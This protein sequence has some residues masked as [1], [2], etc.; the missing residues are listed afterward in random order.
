MNSTKQIT[1]GIC[2]LLFICISK[3]QNTVKGA[4][5]VNQVKQ[6]IDSLLQDYNGHEPGVS[7][8]IL[9]DNELILE[10]QLGLANMEHQIP[11]TTKT[12]FHVA[13]VSKQFTAFAI[14]LLEYEGKLSLDDTIRKY[15]PEM[16]EFEHPITIRNLMNHT[17]GLKDQ[18]N[19]LRLS[20]WT[21]SDLITN[22]QTL[23]ILF[24]QKTLNFQPNEK[25]MY[26]NSGYTLLA[27]IVSRVSNMSFSNFMN[28]NVFRPLQMNDTE[29]VDTEGQI[30]KYKSNSYYKSNSTYKEDLFNNYSVGATNLN[31]TVKD[32]SKWAINFTTKRVGNA[33]IFKKMYLETPLNNGNFYCYASGF[34]INSYKGFERIEHS[35]QDA[36]YQ[37]YLATFPELNLSI[38]FTNT[39]GEINGARMVYDIIDICLEPYV[40]SKKST[41]SSKTLLTHKKPI[42]TTTSYLKQFEGYYWNDKD[43]YSRQ[44]KVQ[45]D[46]LQYIRNNND[47]TG[48]IPV[49]KNE[50]EMVIDEYVSILFQSNQIVLT[51]DDG[52]QITLDKY[53]PVAYDS[54]S[55]KQFVGR[56]Y[57]PELNTY[58]SFSVK[59]NNL[60]ANHTRLGD[61]KLSAIK[62]DYF[63]GNKGSFL[64]VVF[65]RD[66]ADRVMGFNVS[67]SRAKEV[68]FQ[69]LQ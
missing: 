22:D 18:Y 23:Q 11:I 33:S 37:A 63:I 15:L 35:G 29:F 42:R 64:K 28:N 17:S 12:S 8:G 51:L 19:L 9:K 67:S 27:E 13:S 5:D 24:N 32:L 2:M 16:H 62:N 30:V 48:L 50:F 46:T 45:N 60:V 58:Y 57:S 40:D 7:I 52:Y 41:S 43:R 38:I 66:S 14:L 44:L 20:G 54:N 49:D 6:K 1:L 47:K 39:N 31:T 59:D 3:A 65:T 61:F 68:Y 53:I 36:S 26:S 4:F 56:Y 21:L 69:R 10:K 55:I 34:F 25:F